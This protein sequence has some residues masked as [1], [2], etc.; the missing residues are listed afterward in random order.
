MMND[1]EL[2]SEEME[3]AGFWVRLGATLLDTLFVLLITLPLTF[4]LHGSMFPESQTGALMGGRDLVI[5]WILPA[6]AVV[7]FWVF[8]GATPGKMLTSMK[9]VDEKTGRIP[10]ASQSVIRYLAYFVSTLPFCLGFVWIAFDPR[11][12]GWHDKI[13]KTVVIKVSKP[14]A[15]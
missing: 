3:Y 10:S 4:A 11:K 1:I 5:N 12:Q 7:L 15:D 9:V 13:A 6:L 8:K 14:E 2:S